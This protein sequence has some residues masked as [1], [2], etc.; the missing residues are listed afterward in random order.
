VR[1]ESIII[2]DDLENN[3]SSIEIRTKKATGSDKLDFFEKTILSLRLF[4]NN[5]G[6]NT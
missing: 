4:Q 6:I 1:L 3:P 2:V 5:S